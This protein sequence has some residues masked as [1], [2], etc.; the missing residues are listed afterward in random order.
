MILLQNDML[1]SVIS[2]T[3]KIKSFEK[4]QIKQQLENF[5][6]KLV[7]ILIVS[8]ALQPGKSDKYCKLLILFNLRDSEFTRF[9]QLVLTDH[10]TYNCDFFSHY[11]NL[12]RSILN[13]IFVI[14]LMC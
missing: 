11:L 12:S 3:L 2:L 6:A 10:F 9:D 5:C 14:Y 8:Y 7:I 4:S 13:N 1:K